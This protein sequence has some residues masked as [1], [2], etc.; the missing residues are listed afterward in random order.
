MVVS[1]TRADHPHLKRPPVLKK[2][3]EKERIRE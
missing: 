3:G 1:C 2:K